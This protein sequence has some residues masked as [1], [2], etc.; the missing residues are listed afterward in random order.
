MPSN[1]FGIALVTVDGQVYTVGDVDQLFSIQ[2]ISK[3]FTLAEVMQESGEQAIEDSV[4]VDATGQVFNSIVAV[5]QY[6][7]QEMNPFVNP[8]AIATTSMVKGA[9]DAGDLGQDHRHPQRLRR[10]RRSR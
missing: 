5:E 3:V 8:G 7:G 1:L 9:T 2:S 6:K 10:P 4:G